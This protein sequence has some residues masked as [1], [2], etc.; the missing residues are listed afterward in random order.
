LGVQLGILGKAGAWISYK[1]EKIG[2]GKENA[3]Q[4]LIEHPEVAQEI[5]A[6]ILQQFN[7]AGK[8]GDVSET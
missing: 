2:Q 6:M 5:K 7:L 3:R 4:Y 1:D 8:E